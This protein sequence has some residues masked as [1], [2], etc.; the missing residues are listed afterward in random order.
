S[1]TAGEAS[2]GISYAPGLGTKPVGA[3]FTLSSGILW[4]DALS[5]ACIAAL[6]AWLAITRELTLSRPL[7]FAAAMMGLALFI[8]PSEV[9]GATY[10]DVRLGPAIALLGIAALGLRADAPRTAS[11]AVVALAMAL[12]VV[13]AVALTTTWSGY[14]ETIGAIVNAVAKVEPGS[15]LFAA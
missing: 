15:T 7:A 14:N 11:Y 1:P 13:R 8:V 12:G 10:A 6:C 2:K 5:A 3:L 4:L 9:V